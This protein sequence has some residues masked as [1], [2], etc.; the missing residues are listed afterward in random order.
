MK[1]MTELIA[2][3]GD[4]HADYDWAAACVRE[5]AQRG[6]SE[7]LH[8]GD[9]GV[10]FGSN[11][12]YI[13]P[14]EALLARQ[15]LTVYVTPGNHE[16]YDIIDSLPVALPREGMPEGLLQLTEHILLMPRGYRW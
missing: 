4:W 8:V 10:G 2:V 1:H 7:V 9:F 14:L 13:D 12:V 5:L 3:A 11:L 6:F 16:N 15:G